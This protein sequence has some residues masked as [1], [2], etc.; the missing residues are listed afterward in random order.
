[1]PN[2]AEL[3]HLPMTHKDIENAIRKYGAEI[4]KQDYTQ[5]TNHSQNK[6][7]PTEVQTED[8]SEE[9]VQSD[10]ILE[11][12]STLT[13]VDDL[14]N[15]VLEELVRI[16]IDKLIIKLKEIQET[17]VQNLR[18]IVG[19]AKIARQ[20][21]DVVILAETPGQYIFH[22]SENII[23][24]GLGE[25]MPETVLA[26]HS[27]TA[28]R[29]LT[30]LQVEIPEDGLLWVVKK[31]THWYDGQWAVAQ[32]VIH[33]VKSGLSPVEIF[34]YWMTKIMGMPVSYWSRFTGKTKSAI[35][36]RIR[37]AEE[38][39][40]THV[41]P[42]TTYDYFTKTYRSEIIDDKEIITVDNG[43][44]HSRRDIVAPSTKGNMLSGYKGAGS[45]QLAVA[46]LADVSGRNVALG[47]CNELSGHIQHIVDETEDGEWVL[48]KETLQEW[49][50]S[51][52]SE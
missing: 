33:L 42:D 6:N 13:T 34:D 2:K 29:I 14:V 43:L 28:E 1:M 51:Q 8:Y 27:T 20:S 9:F 30:Q 26:V 15:T 19:G 41:Q 11:Y 35:Y 49:I 47:L 4:V 31:P 18:T 48:T 25:K 10:K 7:K 3:S 32:T 40:K 45:R 52:N 12:L 17:L 23:E 22:D 24:R 39:L 50:N 37:K 16:E 38:K 5:I 46:L 36:R 44:L 21:T